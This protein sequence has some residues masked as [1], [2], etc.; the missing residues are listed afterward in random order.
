MARDAISRQYDVDKNRVTLTCETDKG[1]YRP[2]VITFFPKKGKSLDLYKMEE[3]IRATRLSGGTS[4][5]MDFLEV[6]ATGAVVNAADKTTLFQV[7]GASQQ[8]VLKV[9]VSKGSGPSSLERLREALASGAKVVS[10]T[11]RVE[12]WTGK[13]PDVLRSLAKQPVGAPVVLF[14]TDFETKAR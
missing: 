12:G 7:S 4:M 14:V 1:D 3:S 13:F 11:G 10:V 2:G 9:A 5:S 8:F 6:T